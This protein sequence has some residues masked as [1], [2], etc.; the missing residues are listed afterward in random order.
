MD[1]MTSIL[2]SGKEMQRNLTSFIHFSR[3][4]YWWGGGGGGD[5]SVVKRH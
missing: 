4:P 5:S 2:S 1:E 3:L